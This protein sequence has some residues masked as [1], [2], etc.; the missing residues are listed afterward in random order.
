M[1]GGFQTSEDDDNDPDD[2]GTWRAGA[3][4]SVEGVLTGNESIRDWIQAPAAVGG[5]DGVDPAPVCADDPGTP[6][7]PRRQE[8]L[9]HEVGHLMSLS[10][11]DGAI[12]AGTD[13]CGGVML[14][15]TAPRLSS[16]FTQESLHRMRSIESP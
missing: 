9:V 5:G 10:H 2:E 4:R 8:I 3:L 6:R 15:S 13:P 1:Q 14:Y 11:N 12:V 7:S 16:N